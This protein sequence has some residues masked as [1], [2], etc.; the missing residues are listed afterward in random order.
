MF[1]IGGQQVNISPPCVL[2]LKI[3]RNYSYFIC[4]AR[5]HHQPSTKTLKPFIFCPVHQSAGVCRN[6]EDCSQ[7]ECCV[8]STGSRQHRFCLPLRQS[9]EACRLTQQNLAAA[10]NPSHLV[11]LN[12]CPCANGLVCREIHSGWIVD[13]AE[14]V[15][16]AVRVNPAELLRH[17]FL[18]A[19]LNVMKQQQHQ[20][21]KRRT[22]NSRQFVSKLESSVD[23]FTDSREGK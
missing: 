3:T 5:R 15:S 23:L 21:P 12:L 1:L 16:P 20:L 10:G 17:S 6:S 22:K 4:L 2:F 8:R 14:C 18:Q 13:D 19:I 11:Y 7:D 9:G